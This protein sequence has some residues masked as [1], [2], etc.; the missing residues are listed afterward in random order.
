MS[1]NLYSKALQNETAPVKQKNRIRQVTISQLDTGFIV[2]VD[3][4]EFAF[5]DATQM[6]S[7]LIDYV[8]DPLKV[9][10]KYNETGII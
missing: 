1:W 3:C 6:L 5:T 7:K 8:N 10:N 9:E 4:G 2:R